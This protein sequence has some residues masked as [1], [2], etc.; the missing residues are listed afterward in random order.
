[1]VRKAFENEDGTGIGMAEVHIMGRSEADIR[2][3]LTAALD[4]MDSD[5][6]SSMSRQLILAVVPVYQAIVGEWA[7]DKR[8]PQDAV[9][10]LVVLIAQVMSDTILTLG[11]SDIEAHQQF[12]NEIG[13]KV[14]SIV[15][16]GLRAHWRAKSIQ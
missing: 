12:A 2:E 1:M 7:K 3:Q 11:R 6:H 10:A 16:G 14:S 9:S 5:G 8:D 4:A 13:R 15:S